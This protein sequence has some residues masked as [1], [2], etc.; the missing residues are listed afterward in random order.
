MPSAYYVLGKVSVEII[1]L[2]S[3]CPSIN[4]AK[5]FAYMDK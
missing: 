3:K 1:R 5:F 4:H 2:S